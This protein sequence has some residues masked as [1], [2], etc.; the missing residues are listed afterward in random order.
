MVIKVVKHVSSQ[1]VNYVFL[2]MIASPTYNLYPITVGEDIILP[3]NE[4]KLTDKS[5][6]EVYNTKISVAKRN[7]DLLYHSAS[8]YSFLNL[9]HIGV[10]TRQTASP[11][12]ETNTHISM[13]KFQPKLSASAAKP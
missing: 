1:I 6:F 8:E 13:V 5:K 9:F 2:D 10:D 11:A 4:Q 7:G 3:Q 12:S